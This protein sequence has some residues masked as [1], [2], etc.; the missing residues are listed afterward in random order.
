MDLTPN[1]NYPYPQC[2]PPLVEDASNAPVQTRALAEA[3]DADFTTVDT[4]IRDTYQL[5]TTILRISSS[6]SIA[7]G[8]DVPFDVV[9]YDPEGWA[10]GDTVQAPS[11]LWLVCGFAACASGENVQ[12][13][14]VQFS[15]DGSGFFLQGTSP[16]ASNRGQ[17]TAS[18]VTIRTAGAALGMRV[19]YSGTSPSNFDNCWF[20][21]TR[22]VTL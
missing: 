14:A 11:G 6:T 2:S 1:R 21:A 5:R 7:S 15:G 17:M 9:E 19:F 12:Q 3:M 16:T 13:L 20:S 18:G 4:L 22:M 8:D 10:N